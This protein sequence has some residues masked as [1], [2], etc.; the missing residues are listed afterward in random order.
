MLWCQPDF[1]FYCYVA[2]SII[3]I[4]LADCFSLSGLQICYQLCV[5]MQVI[6]A[7]AFFSFGHVFTHRSKIHLAFIQDVKW[8]WDQLE[9]DLWIDCLK[10]APV[11]SPTDWPE[12]WGPL[13]SCTKLH[14][15]CH[16]PSYL[17]LLWNVTQFF[18]VNQPTT[19][20]LCLSN[21]T[22]FTSSFHVVVQ[23]KPVL[24]LPSMII[25]PPCSRW[26]VLK[27]N[28]EFFFHAFF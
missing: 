3:K 14:K 7:T 28:L 2:S 20:H 17:L 25:L 15:T 22:W 9:Q 23:G 21:K 19:T 1:N 12:M 13:I 27:C 18:P 8:T 16:F 11:S 4:T 26:Q 5:I 24:H 10:W 6:V